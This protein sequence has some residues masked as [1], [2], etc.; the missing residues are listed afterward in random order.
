[1]TKKDVI[2]YISETPENTNMNILNQFLDELSE[3]NSNPNYI[4]TVEGTLD[5]PWGSI[6]Y[7]GLVTACAANNANATLVF[8]I[9]RGNSTFT[10]SAP[11]VMNDSSGDFTLA[12]YYDPTSSAYIFA[13]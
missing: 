2:D 8:A 3:G 5:N 12:S 11:M 7:H 10:A 1:M 4:E 13:F 6:D 9:K